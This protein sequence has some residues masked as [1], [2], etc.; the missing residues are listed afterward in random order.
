[1]RCGASLCC[2]AKIFNSVLRWLQA[3]KSASAAVLSQV[4]QHLPCLPSMAL[5]RSRACSRPSDLA[6]TRAQWLLQKL[7][8]QQLNQGSGV[9]DVAGGRG[10]LS[11]HL[12]MRGVR[13]TCVDRR[14]FKPCKAML[15]CETRCPP[16]SASPP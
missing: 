5:S 4:S 12:H 14:A 3:P 15:K 2:G 6:L 11:F 13:A 9:L 1:M 10:E 16:C 7:S 8:V